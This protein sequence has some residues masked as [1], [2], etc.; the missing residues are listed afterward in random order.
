MEEW[1]IKLEDSYL[2][3]DLNALELIKQESSDYLKYQD[4]DLKTLSKRTYTLLS[5]SLSFIGVLISILFARFSF[6]ATQT[7]KFL[8][9]LILA[10]C[11]ILIYCCFLLTRILLPEELHSVGIPP[12]YFHFDDLEKMT[13]EEQHNSILCGIIEIYQNS[14]VVNEKV[15]E[16]RINIFEKVLN[17]FIISIICTIVLMIVIHLM[18]N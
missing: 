5:I 3:L 4:L 16:K 7:D 15:L 2:K 18:S 13:K 10:L 6:I 8:I 14:I 9:F 12:E 1:K 17:I 11:C